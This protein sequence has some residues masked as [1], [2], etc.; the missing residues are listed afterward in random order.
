MKNAYSDPSA[1]Q[2]P[3]S[4]SEDHLGFLRTGIGL[5][6]LLSALAG[7]TPPTLVTTTTFSIFKH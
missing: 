2:A 4:I 5:S 7:L 1:Y 6:W 3:E